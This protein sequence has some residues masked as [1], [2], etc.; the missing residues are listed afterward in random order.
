QG[1]Q[2]EPDLAQEVHG[3]EILSQRRRHR[4]PFHPTRAR[5]GPA[6]RGAARRRV[7]GQLT[8][9]T[10]W[11]TMALSGGGQAMGWAY[12]LSSVGQ[13][14][15]LVMLYCVSEEQMRT[16]IAGITSCCRCWTR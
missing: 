7:R 16:G 2:V 6:G 14:V 11:R 4:R 15:P 8:G 10:A 3:L 12:S 1:H 13:L 9:V 5:G